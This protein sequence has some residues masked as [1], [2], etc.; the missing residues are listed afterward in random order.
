MLPR[1][2][3][4]VN[5]EFSFLRRF[6]SRLLRWQRRP[7]GEPAAEAVKESVN[8]IVMFPSPGSGRRM[9]YEN[10]TISLTDLFTKRSKSFRA[11]E[12]LNTSRRVNSTGAS[13]NVGSVSLK[14]LRESS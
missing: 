2:R 13:L 6:E 8:E 10:M 3:V 4:G 14:P 11:M 5:P 12:K 1:Q 9:P 7:P